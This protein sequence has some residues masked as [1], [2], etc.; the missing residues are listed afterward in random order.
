MQHPEILCIDIDWLNNVV[1][2]K[3]VA[4]KCVHKKCGK[5]AQCFSYNSHHCCYQCLPCDQWN[6]K[7]VHKLLIYPLYWIIC[8]LHFKSI[9]MA[10]CIVNWSPE[11]NINIS[12]VCCILAMNLIANWIFINFQKFI[13][14]YKQFTC[15]WMNWGKKYWSSEINIS[16]YTYRHIE[17]MNWDEPPIAYSIKYAYV[18][19]CTVRPRLSGMHWTR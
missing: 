4:K 18:F 11:Q 12:L 8:R 2:T 3:I 7:N 19:V 1:C 6:C 13:I 14:I 17:H 5:Y 9:C 15:T 16:K 10:E